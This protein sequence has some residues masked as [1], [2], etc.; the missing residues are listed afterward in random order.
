MKEKRLR[1]IGCAVVQ[2]KRGEENE[3]FKNGCEDP[4]V[5]REMPDLHGPLLEFC[6]P[7]LRAVQSADGCGKRDPD[8]A[9]PG[10]D[11][12]VWSGAGHSAEYVRIREGKLI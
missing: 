5:S 3:L 6:I 9:D 7:D 4:S 1:T 10:K 12:L 11:I 8:R 2:K